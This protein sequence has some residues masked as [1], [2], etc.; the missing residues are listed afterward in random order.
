MLPS[1]EVSIK[2]DKG[3]HQPQQTTSTVVA[4]PVIIP[5][6]QES[7]AVPVNLNQENE[8]DKDKAQT[9]IVTGIHFCSS[10]SGFN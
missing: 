6:P 1:A 2:V 5:N 4:P 10:T 8:N 9:A 7:A 3:D